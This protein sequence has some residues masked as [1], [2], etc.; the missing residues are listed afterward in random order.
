[1]NVKQ[2]ILLIDDY[3]PLRLSLSE[4]LSELY[5][6]YT[7]ENGI[8]ALEIIRQINIDLILLDIMLPFP[9]DGF[10]ILKILKSDPKLASIPVIIISALE[11]EEKV[12]YGLKNGAN[13][14]LIKPFS[15]MLLKLKINNLLTIKENI[16]KNLE[17]EFAVQNNFSSEMT[18]VFEVNFKRDFDR[19]IHELINDRN[20]TVTAV[21]DQM[22]I[23]ITTLER[24]VRKIYG[25]VP[26]K[27][28]TNL[29]LEKAEIMLLQKM[30]TVAEI[31][32]A[33][34]FNSGS[35]FCTCFKEKYAKTPYMVL[36]QNSIN[37]K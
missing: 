21:A 17:K 1:M 37:Q 23:S 18:D 4:Y 3:K 25:V 32:E 34:G 15:E 2:N 36:R 10:A 22:A 5:Q 6:V 9:L 13:D 24:W 8:N 19:V 12:L 30:G 28:I 31:A 35:Y 27:Y 11:Q 7:A 20:C 33:A 16:L 29:K 14:Y 26:Q